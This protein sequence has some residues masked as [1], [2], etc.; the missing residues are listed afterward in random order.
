MSMIALSGRIAANP[1]GTYLQTCLALKFS[2]KRLYLKLYMYALIILSTL[3]EV[4][5]SSSV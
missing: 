3:A 2:R 1:T 5:P 4:M